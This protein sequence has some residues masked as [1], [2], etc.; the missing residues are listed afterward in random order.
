MSYIQ[1]LCQFIKSSF[2]NIKIIAGGQG[3]FYPEKFLIENKNVDI[4]CYGRE[5]E[6]SFTDL[7]HHLLGD[8]LIPEVKGIFYRDEQTG[9]V[10]KTPSMDRKVDLSKLND[11]YLKYPPKKLTHKGY[12]LYVVLEIYRGCYYKCSYCAWGTQINKCFFKDLDHIIAEMNSFPEDTH[13]EVGDSYINTPQ[14]VYVFSN[15]A[16]KFKY[17]SVNVEHRL[18]KHLTQEVMDS[19]DSFDQVLI[20]IGVQSFDPK[21]LKAINRSNDI[22]ILQKWSDAYKGSKKR[23]LS[24]HILMGLPYQTLAILKKDIET[25]SYLG[26]YMVFAVIALPGSEYWETSSDWGGFFEDAYPFSF[27]ESDYIT[28]DEVAYVK[29]AYGFIKEQGVESPSHLEE[30]LLGDIS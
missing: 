22:S 2:P 24:F 17:I 12:P 14:H 25:V 1:D 6:E 26:T 29:R 28:S 27:L 4:F 15:L 21:I 9:S 7:V 8:K 3:V 16:K 30:N 5:G 19:F 13:F 10:E 23:L 20:D 18:N 11:I